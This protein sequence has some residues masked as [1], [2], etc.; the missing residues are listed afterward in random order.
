MTSN[1]ISRNVFYKSIEHSVCRFWS[2]IHQRFIRNMCFSQLLLKIPTLFIAE[3]LRKDYL[4]FT[5]YYVRLFVF[6]A[7]FFLFFT[8]LAVFLIFIFKGFAFYRCCHSYADLYLFLYKTWV[9][10]ILI[11][12]FHMLKMKVSINFL[13][14]VCY[15]LF[16][17]CFVFIWD[18]DIVI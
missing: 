17:F 4:Y 9:C 12:K 6:N 7:H 11:I 5:M 3:T 8:C 10:V 1:L 18:R 16:Y 15:F 13:P 2:W 14:Q